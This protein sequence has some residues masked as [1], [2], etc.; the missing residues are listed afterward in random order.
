MLD[1]SES[2]LYC[3]SQLTLAQLVLLVIFLQALQQYVAYVQLDHIQQ[4]QQLYALFVQ[5]EPMW[6]HRVLL[7][8]VHVAVQIIAYQGPRSKHSVL[9]V[10][11]AQLQL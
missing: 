11:T 9:L 1:M 3:Q 6:L 8:A 4:L 7:S 10:L 2:Q 5:Q